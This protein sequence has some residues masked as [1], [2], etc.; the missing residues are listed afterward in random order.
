MR[1]FNF[2]KDAAQIATS[3]PDGTFHH[4][5]KSFTSG[6]P[7][8]R[9]SVAQGSPFAAATAAKGGQFYT[10][11]HC[12]PLLKV[13]PMKRFNAWLRALC[14]VQSPGKSSSY[15]GY[16]AIAGSWNPDLY[17]TIAVQ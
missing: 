8:H 2:E 12:M 6:S 1:D 14:R 15:E 16:Q 7:R 4:S 5:L 3:E 9:S 10:D 13:L 17:G 11:S